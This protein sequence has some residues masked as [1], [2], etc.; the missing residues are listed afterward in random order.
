M[1]NIEGI[2]GSDGN[3]MHLIIPTSWQGKSGEEE[4]EVGK[5]REI[6][7]KLGREGS[8]GGSCAE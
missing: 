2:E 6:P 4:N 7:V 3:G 1:E 5:G 8:G